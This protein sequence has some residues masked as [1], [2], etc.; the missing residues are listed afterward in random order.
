MTGII[1]NAVGVADFPDKCQVVGSAA[2]EPFR[3]QEFPLFFEN[4]E[5][6]FELRLDAFES[7][8]GSVIGGDEV[9]GREKEEVVHFVDNGARNRVNSFDGSEKAVFDFN[10]VNNALGDGHNF[11]GV[12]EGAESTTLEVGVGAR[13]MDIYQF[14]N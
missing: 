4:F 10:P 3:F 9:F 12:A 7:A 8:L 5:P 11:D 13:I 1:L 2:L 6:F 14:S